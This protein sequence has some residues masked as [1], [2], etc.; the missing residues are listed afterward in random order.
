MTET[1]TELAIRDVQGTV[2]AESVE[3]LYKLLESTKNKAA[4]LPWRANI[5][6][7]AVRDMVYAIGGIPEYVPAHHVGIFAGH[8]YVFA[9]G[10]V[11]VAIDNG[12]T[13]FT[14]P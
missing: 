13:V 5:L 2:V 11:D 7:V 8:P 12:C 14:D 9:D 6:P 1:R 4:P 10:T 3:R